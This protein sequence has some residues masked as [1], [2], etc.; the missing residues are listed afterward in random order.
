[1]IIETLVVGMLQTNCYLLGDEKSRQ[2]V[3]IDPGGDSERIVRRV[4]HLGLDLSAILH[5]H[6]HFDHIMDAWTVK[7]RLGG[8]IYLH[9]KDEPIF[10]QSMAG[11]GSLFAPQRQ[12]A[13]GTID[14]Y[15][16]EGDSLAF[17]SILL[18]VLETPGHS[19]GHISLLFPE[20]SII[21][22]GDTLFAGSIGRTDLPGGSYSQLIRSVREKIFPLEGKTI[23]YPGHGPRTTVEHEKK[24]NPFFR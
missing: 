21:F 13:S 17:G 2:A 4:Q 23:V 10:Q 7:Q 18:Q 15:L 3:V 24:S 19:P 5:T 22:V 9:A 6:G 20:A 8:K 14:H 1:M 12:A 11:M 16:T